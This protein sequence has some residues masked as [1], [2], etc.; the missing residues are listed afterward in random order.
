MKILQRKSVSSSDVLGEI[1]F[2]DRIVG[3]L[4]KGENTFRSKERW[5]EDTIWNTEF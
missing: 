1:K 5:R 3:L 4:N 2:C